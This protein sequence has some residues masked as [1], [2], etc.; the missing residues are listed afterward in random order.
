[1]GKRRAP[2]SNFPNHAEH[3][4]LP[5]LGS[6]ESQETF[7]STVKANDVSQAPVA[8]R[9]THDHLGLRKFHYKRKDSRRN[10]QNGDCKVVILA[11]KTRTS[12]RKPSTILPEMLQMWVLS[13]SRT[14]VPK[15]ES[16]WRP[17]ASHTVGEEYSTI[18]YRMA[19]GEMVPAYLTHLYLIISSFEDLSFLR[20][21]L[22]HIWLT[23][24]T[25]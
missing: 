8:N 23:T 24:G 2:I 14:R 3:L 20:A 10:V 19:D 5:R 11:A 1:M 18:F 13:A 25:K 22:A 21:L 15:I 16:D 6:R 12:S 9:E 7:L 17:A 4:S